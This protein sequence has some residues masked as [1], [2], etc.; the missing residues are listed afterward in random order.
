M[1]AV[2]RAAIAMAVLLSSVLAFAGRSSAQIYPSG[3]SV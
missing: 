1:P 2:Y 3:R